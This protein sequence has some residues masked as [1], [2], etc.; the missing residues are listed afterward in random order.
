ME[1]FNK[2]ET[3]TLFLYAVVF[4]ILLIIILNAI[5]K[6][7]IPIMIVFGVYIYIKYFK[8]DKARCKE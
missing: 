3:K 7:I 8:K 4:L 5:L 2:L 6:L 1:E